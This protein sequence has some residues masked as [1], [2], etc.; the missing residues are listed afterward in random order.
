M[1]QG[2]ELLKDT[3]EMMETQ[4]FY[5]LEWTTKQKRILR[6]LKIIMAPLYTPKALQQP[7]AIT[8]SLHVLHW[9]S[10]QFL[11]MFLLLEQLLFWAIVRWN[12]RFIHV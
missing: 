2:A 11:C 5:P 1:K 3:Q 8:H 7:A 12:F 10:L 4:I 6:P 9:F